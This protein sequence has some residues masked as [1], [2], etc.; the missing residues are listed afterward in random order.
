MGEI[1]AKRHRIEEDEGLEGKEGLH[2]SRQLDDD[3]QT[4][5]EQ[6]NR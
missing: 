2:P 5:G 4:N 3:L 1:D 6:Q